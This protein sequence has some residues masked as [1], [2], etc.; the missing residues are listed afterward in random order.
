MELNHD[1]TN[2]IASASCRLV[3]P[4]LIQLILHSRPLASKPL[5][6]RSLD[7]SVLLCHN[8]IQRLRNPSDTFSHIELIYKHGL[9]TWITCV[10]NI[11]D[12]SVP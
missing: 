11:S 3:T 4:Q 7:S 1:M 6:N 5:F 10:A 12:S 8:D 2:I 9:Q